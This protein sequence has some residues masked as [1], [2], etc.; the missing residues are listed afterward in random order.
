MSFILR[1]MSVLAG[2]P[3]LLGLSLRYLTNFLVQISICSQYI[4]LLLRDG[5]VAQFVELLPSTRR[6][7][8]S[9]LTLA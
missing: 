6:S 1:P 2:S 9:I 7:L 3:L 4:Y 8:G 5:D